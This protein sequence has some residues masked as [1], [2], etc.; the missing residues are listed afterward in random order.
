MFF[1]TR[2]FVFFGTF[3]TLVIETPAIP[4]GARLTKQMES[5]EVNG[6][7]DAIRSVEG[8]KIFTHEALEDMAAKPEGSGLTLMEFHE[9]AGRVMGVDPKHMDRFVNAYLGLLTHQ[10][11]GREKVELQGLYKDHLK[12]VQSNKGIK[13]KGV[14]VL[15]ELI[16]KINKDPENQVKEEITLVGYFLNKVDETVFPAEE[17]TEFLCWKTAQIWRSR[18]KDTEK[19]D[20]LDLLDEYMGWARKHSR[21]EDTVYVKEWVN[22]NGDPKKNE[23]IMRLVEGLKRPS[24]TADAKHNE[25][26]WHWRSIVHQMAN[27]WKKWM[28]RSSTKKSE[29]KLD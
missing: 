5:A 21:L 3:L 9:R 29:E 10:D 27:L 14:Q 17:Q 15:E 19:L 20:I 2:A 22:G 12:W 4:T 24:E 25:P 7:K 8:S 16:E 18:Y 13:D 11:I 28:K 6:G 26:W 1:L 23:T